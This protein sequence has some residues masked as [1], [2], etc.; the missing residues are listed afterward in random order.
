MNQNSPDNNIFGGLLKSLQKKVVFRVMLVVLTIVLA[1]ILV[2]SLTIAWQ[3]NVIQ[4]G[5]LSFSAESWNF[6]GQ[7]LMEDDNIVMAP[8]DSGVV[9]LTLKNESQSLVAASITLSKEQMNIAQN[10]VFFYIDSQE[11]RNGEL[12][13]RVYI[14]SKKSY[15]YTMFPFSEI[16]IDEKT[17]NQPQLKWE[18]VYDNLGYYVLGHITDNGGVLVE[19][20]LSPIIYEY[21]ELMTTFH[22]N[23]DLKTID[24]IIT[25][26]EF[27]QTYS[28]IDGYPGKID[29]SQKTTGGYYPVSVNDGYGV[30][31][32]LCN[33]SEIQKGISDDTSL[34][35][36]ST[37]FG[38]VNLII[39]GQNSREQGVLVHNEESLITALSTPGINVITL[40]NDIELTRPIV[41]DSSS[42]IMVDLNGNTITSSADTIID[43]QSG[44][45]VMLYDGAV[46]GISKIN[47]A[48]TMQGGEIT[49]D[50]VKIS[51]VAEGIVVFDHKDTNSIDSAIHLIDCEILADLDGLWIYGNAAKS[52]NPVK[53]VVENCNIVG[54]NYAGILC[55][56]QYYG[57]D[58]DI[59]DSEI[60]GYWAAVYFPQKNSYLNIDNCTL[61]GH[62]GLVVKGGFVIV[63]DCIITGIGENEGLPETPE[64]LGMSGWVS[65]GDGVYLEAN[66]VDRESSITI[67]G[68]K[69]QVKGTKETTEAVRLFPND[70]NYAQAQIK[71]NGGSYNT[72]IT[73]Y[74]QE[75]YECKQQDGMYVVTKIE[76]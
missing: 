56:G 60:S 3:I 2:F 35:E 36:T 24:G 63:N 37:A 39:T 32:Y 73:E 76:S 54:E 70:P 65:T 68:S 6:S 47:N 67:S 52:E 4:T 5:G 53:I 64:K 55:N 44:G 30:W 57:T 8:G 26:E 49:L 40:H 10:R 29:V 22:E 28:E 75:G 58:I 25:A 43:V 13:D 33:Y 15:T 50:K 42:I 1:A 51:N 46:E 23:G 71:I 11:Y 9:P 14:S 45:K 17:R 31:A 74:L 38:N 69:T 18:W 41:S 20:Y 12:M 16:V 19:D 72:D 59:I 21:D 48:I 27:L 61:T 62:N 34:G 7:V 66:Y